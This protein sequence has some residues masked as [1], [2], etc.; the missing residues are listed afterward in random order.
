MK[1][2]YNFLYIKE[3]FSGHYE[4]L[5]NIKSKVS[6]NSISFEINLIKKNYNF[7]VKVRRF[8]NLF[9]KKKN[10]LIFHSMNLKIL[11]VFK[12]INL[13]QRRK[14]KIGLNSTL[15]GSDDLNTIK[16]SRL[17]TI[18]INLF[19]FFI[20]NS[21]QLYNVSLSILKNKKKSYLIHSAYTRDTISDDFFLD[22][23]Q[24]KTIL[25]VGSLIHR[26]GIDRLCALFK[27][28]NEFRFIIIGPN[29]PP[30]I[31]SNDVDY[32]K[33]LKKRFGIS[34]KDS[35]W[36]ELGM[37]HHKDIFE[38]YISSGYFACLSRNEGLPSVLTDAVFMNKSLLLSSEMN[39]LFNENF[40]IKSKKVHHLSDEQIFE[41]KINILNNQNIKFPKDKLKIFLPDYVFKQYISLLKEFS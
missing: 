28:L 35:R 21:Y 34:E 17:G 18:K 25:F 36:N 2:I 20:S 6:D 16:N 27:N 10:I 3:K 12:L 30:F 24:K 40:R 32:L 13:F 22:N 33:N 31:S 4:Y 37:I 14:V 23:Q 1:N 29:S 15:F 41:K 39:E 8:Y 11:I 7:F 26:K 19:D 9:F 5:K 38:Y